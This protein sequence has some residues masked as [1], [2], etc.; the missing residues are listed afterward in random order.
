LLSCKLESNQVISIKVDSGKEI[1]LLP[2]FA[3]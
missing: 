3:I 1:L 2:K